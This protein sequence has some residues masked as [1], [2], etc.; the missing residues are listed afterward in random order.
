MKTFF[1]VLLFSLGSLFLLMPTEVRAATELGIFPPIIKVRIKP[2]TTLRQ[3]I[4]LYNSSSSTLYLTWQLRAFHKT[5]PQGQPLWSLEKAIPSWIKVTGPIDLKKKAYPL[6]PQSHQDFLLTLSPPENLPQ[7]DYYYSLLFLSSPTKEN[8]QVRFQPGI[9]TNLLISVTDTLQK[10]PAPPIITT[11]SAPF[12]LDSW[13]RRIKTKVKIYNP[14]DQWIEVLPTLKL[15]KK[16]GLGK[17][18]EILN[19]IPVT[20]LKGNKRSIFLTEKDV[21]LAITPNRVQDTFKEHKNPLQRIKDKFFSNHKPVS[22]NSINFYSD[23]FKL[24]LY[25]YQLQIKTSSKTIK[26]N[27]TIIFFPWKLTL[28]IFSLVIAGYFIRRKSEA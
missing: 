28:G 19:F 6:K 20:V 15:E 23:S 4:R 16:I 7:K 17:N 14:N 1:K 21:E 8:T 25:N 22:D 24:G 2:G 12:F 27:K 5:T 18:E 13:Q 9:A 10:K 26:E 11:F 3:P